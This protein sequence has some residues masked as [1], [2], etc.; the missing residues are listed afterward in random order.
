MK[1]VLKL[2]GIIVL[3]AVIGFSMAGCFPIDSAGDPDGNGTGGSGDPWDNAKIV[4]VGYSS[5]HTIAS[6][7]QHW[8]KYVGTGE[9]VIFETKG[10]VVDTYIGYGTSPGSYLPGG[11]D[12]SG[13]GYNGLCSLNTTVGTTYWIKITPRSGTSGTYTFVVTAPTFNIRTNPIQVTAGYSSPHVINSSGQHWFSFQASGNSI[14]FE[15]EGNVVNTSISIFIGDSTSEFLIH[16]NRISFTTISG[17][18]YYIRITSSSNGSYD[19][20]SGTYTFKVRNGSGDG[21]SGNYAIPVTV[22]YS[23]SHTF[24]LSSDELWFSFL[25]TGNTVIFYILCNVVDTYI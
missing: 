19:S 12:N 10:N 24:N 15:T 8:F 2:A 20:S 14:V 16:N 25:G 6:N 17:S 3:A 9:P 11:N 21:S 1:N 22:G 7:G 23:S 5:S 13:E 18:T 4:T